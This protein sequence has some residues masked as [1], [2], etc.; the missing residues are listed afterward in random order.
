[1]TPKVLIRERG[2]HVDMNNH[3]LRDRIFQLEKQIKIAKKKKKDDLS[4]EIN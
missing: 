3:P 1:M 4:R 2:I